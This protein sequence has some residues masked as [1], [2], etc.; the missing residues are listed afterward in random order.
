[1]SLDAH[2]DPDKRI[3]TF[4]IY[5]EDAQIMGLELLAIALGLSKFGSMIKNRNLVIHSD[6]TGSEVRTAPCTRG[7]S[8]MSFCYSLFFKVALR[9]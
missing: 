7:F 2:V 5:R 6:N 1:M 4:P 3:G 8:F 9:R